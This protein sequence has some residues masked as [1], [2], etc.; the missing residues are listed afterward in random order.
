[1]IRPCVSTDKQVQTL[2]DTTSGLSEQWAK[3]T[4]YLRAALLP[5]AVCRMGID[6]IITSNASCYLLTVQTSEEEAVSLLKPDL[7]RRISSS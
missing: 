2:F 4:A 1:M 7:C 5:A 6:H 3:L